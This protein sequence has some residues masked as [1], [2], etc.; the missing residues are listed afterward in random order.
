M[1][2]QG[3]LHCF[4]GGSAH[5]EGHRGGDLAA[6]R[7][8]HRGDDLLY[9]LLDLLARVRHQLLHLPGNGVGRR[10]RHHGLCRRFRARDGTHFFGDGRMGCW[11]SF[12]RQGFLRGE[13]RR[14]CRRRLWNRRGRLGRRRR[15]FPLVPRPREP[16]V[17]WKCHTPDVARGFQFHAHLEEFTHG[18]RP[19]DPGNACARM[20]RGVSRFRVRHFKIHPAVARHIMFGLVAAAVAAQDK[21]RGALLEGLSQ[22]VLAG[23]GKRHGL[24]DPRAP[25][26]LRLLLRRFGLFDHTLPREQRARIAPR[27]AARGSRRGL[28]R[29]G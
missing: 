2:H 20:P 11:R 7:G 22:R 13:H 10:S 3:L 8:H 4:G 18:A 6:F 17:R 1:G 5:L 24:H 29:I 28:M 9:V 16:V 14:G 15:R 25:P 23:N 12:E 21:R 27:A 26:A 19:L